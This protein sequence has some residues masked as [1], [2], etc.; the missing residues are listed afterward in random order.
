MYRKHHRLVGWLEAS[1]GQLDSWL[2]GYS[3]R[4]L[5]PSSVLFHV[6]SLWGSGWGSRS[7]PVLVD[8]II[9]QKCSLPPT[10]LPWEDPLAPWHCVFPCD[11]LWP[12]KLKVVKH[13]RVESACVYT[14]STVI[15]MR[16]IPW[17]ILPTQGENE[18][19]K[20]EMSKERLNLALPPPLH[21]RLPM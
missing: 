14:S 9:V 7:Y 8:R 11:F 5:A 4:G 6:L 20:T 19:L 12:I 2:S 17:A 10:Q 13:Q 3:P 1:G 15:A 18:R 21:Q 16:N